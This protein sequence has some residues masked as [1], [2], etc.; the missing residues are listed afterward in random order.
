ML[1]EQT[2]LTRG[3]EASAR[4]DNLH[5][6]LNTLD[7]EVMQ[8]D[9]AAKQNLR[10]AI[11]DAGRRGYYA[12]LREQVIRIFVPM[13]PP[14]VN[15]Y[16]N[17][18]F[19]KVRDELKEFKDWIALSCETHQIQ[20]IPGKV[21]VSISIYRSG[22]GDLDNYIKPILDALQEKAFH[23]DGDVIELHAYLHKATSKDDCKCVVFVSASDQSS[24]EG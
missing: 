23:D 8:S 16:V 19:N 7:R 2:A 18:R 17:K 15:K 1:D 14:S 3:Y 21:S 11:N 13:L 12:F 20:P 9:P 22:R 4:R 5:D 6:F 24:G 10:L